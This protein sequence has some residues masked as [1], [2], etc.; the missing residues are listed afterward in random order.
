MVMPGEASISSREIT[1]TL[2][3][4]SSAD[5]G[6]PRVALTTIGGSVSVS[7]V[8]PV[9]LGVSWATAQKLWITTAQTALSGCRYG[10]M[11]ALLRLVTQ[12][13]RHTQ[14]SVRYRGLSRRS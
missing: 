4:R 11:I 14:A 7:L 10:M 5:R 2:T 6:R 8:Y 3:G 1:L 9:L 13:R 12:H